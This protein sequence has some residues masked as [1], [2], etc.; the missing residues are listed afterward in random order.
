MGHPVGVGVTPLGQLRGAINSE[1][2]G[3]PDAE[4]K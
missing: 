1:P 4:S 2:G 3:E